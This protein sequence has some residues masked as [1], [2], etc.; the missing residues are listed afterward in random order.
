MLEPMPVLAALAVTVGVNQL[1]I[2]VS[3][4]GPASV[5]VSVINCYA[6]AQKG[7]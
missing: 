1:L 6:D 2:F 3:K 7:R 4:V 5:S